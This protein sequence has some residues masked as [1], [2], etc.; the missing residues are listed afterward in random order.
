MAKITINENAFTYP[1]SMVVVGTLVD[2]RPNFMAVGLKP[3][4]MAKITVV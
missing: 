2:E 4:A 3:H 1:M